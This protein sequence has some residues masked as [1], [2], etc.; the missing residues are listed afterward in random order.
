MQDESGETIS[1]FG[2]NDTESKK[3]EEQHEQ[4][5]ESDREKARTMWVAANTERGEE[6]KSWRMF[7]KTNIEYSEV[8]RLLRK[9]F[10]VSRKVG[11]KNIYKWNKEFDVPDMQ[12]PEFEKTLDYGPKHPEFT[13]AGYIQRAMD[14]KEER[15]DEEREK[16]QSEDGKK[17]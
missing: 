14:E 4:V 3:I 11:G 7:Q 17:E 5:K 10:E 13:Q 15:A 16:E 8:Q 12:E 6:I 9:Y 2:E 1:D